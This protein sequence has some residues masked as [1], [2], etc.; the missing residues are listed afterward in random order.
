MTCDPGSDSRPISARRVGMAERAWLWCKRRPAVAA[1]AAAVLLASIRRHGGGDRG[2]GQGQRRAEGRQ[3]E[4]E[5]A[6]QHWR[7]T[8]SSCS[9]A[10]SAKT[11]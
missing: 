5:A 2:A 3:P 9:T 7:W 10:K 4:R 6:V 11:C 1:L 8:R